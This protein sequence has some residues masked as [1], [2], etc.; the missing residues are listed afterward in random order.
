MNFSQ[1]FLF[2]IFFQSSNYFHLLLG[3]LISTTPSTGFSTTPS[4]GFST[5][6]S[7]GFSTTPSTGLFFLFY[8]TYFSSNFPLN[9]SLYLLL[10]TLSPKL[11][12]ITKYKIFQI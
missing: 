7:T 4:T 12:L 8:S 10:E 6:P 1:I 5:T 9:T 11:L 3:G 2:I